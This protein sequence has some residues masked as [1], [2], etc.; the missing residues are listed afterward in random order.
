ML[1]PAAIA[2]PDGLH[3][4]YHDRD[5]RTLREAYSPDGV[6]WTRFQVIDG[7]GGFPG[8]TSDEVGFYPCA[9]VLNHGGTTTINVFYTDATVL[10]MRAAQLVVGPTFSGLWQFGVVDPWAGLP[11][12]TQYA[13]VIHDS[14]MQVSYANDFGQLSVAYGTGP[15]AFKLAAVDGQGPGDLTHGNGSLQDPM[16][17][18]VTAVEANGTAPSVFYVDNIT[19]MLRHAYWK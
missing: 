11:Y 19:G 9:I 2:A 17:F 5:H 13:P 14:G 7:P 1:E 10:R 3:V 6:S 18:Y 8:S 12:S 16:G 15:G 4:D